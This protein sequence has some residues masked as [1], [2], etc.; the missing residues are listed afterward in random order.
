MEVQNLVK[1]LYDNRF[2][3]SDDEYESFQ[4]A[5]D[6]IGN[7]ELE[8]ETIRDLYL[9]FEDHTEEYEVMW[10][11]LHLLE[12]VDPDNQNLV[13]SLVKMVPQSKEW[14][15]I[16]IRRILKTPVARMNFKQ[17][18]QHADKETKEIIKSLL[19]EIGESNSK[20]KENIDFILN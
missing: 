1:I 9:V 12:H 4:K 18:Y 10:G 6:L 3:R 2:I 17:K 14:V 16:F 5:L 7:E 8:E 20:F 13:K 11:L 19:Q 15:T